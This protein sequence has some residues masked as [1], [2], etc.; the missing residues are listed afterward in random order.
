MM[1]ITKI[2]RDSRSKD[3]C[4]ISDGV[5]AP[6][7]TL[8]HSFI[9]MFILH[10]YNH[11][12]IVLN[13]LL[14]ILV[15]GGTGSAAPWRPGTGNRPRRPPQ[16]WRRRATFLRGGRGRWFGWGGGLNIKFSRDV[17]S[18]LTPLTSGLTH[19]RTA[20]SSRIRSCFRIGKKRDLYLSL[21]R[22]WFFQT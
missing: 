19:F 2:S 14:S 3:K 17:T 9:S 12:G 11:L 4:H 22:S 18:G 10:H 5:Q 16:W 8:D 15:S 7:V 13:C 1:K 6:N 21:A 20:M